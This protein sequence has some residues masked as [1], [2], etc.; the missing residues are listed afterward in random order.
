MRGGSAATLTATLSRREAS[1]SCRS[2][3]LFDVLRACVDSSASLA[4]LHGV[5]TGPRGPAWAASASVELDPDEP[6]TSPTTTRRG[7][8][9]G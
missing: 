2:R 5:P 9:S 8:A 4:V 1:A 7:C 6:A 3:I